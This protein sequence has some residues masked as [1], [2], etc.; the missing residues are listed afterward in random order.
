MSVRNVNP[1]IPTTRM[2]AE[3]MTGNWSIH[4]FGPYWYELSTVET[5]GRG[6]SGKWVSLSLMITAPAKLGN[7][8]VRTGGRRAR[9]SLEGTT[10][11]AGVRGQTYR[12]SDLNLIQQ[13]DRLQS[14]NNVNS[15]P[16]GGIIDR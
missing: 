5:G 4:G 7:T 6:M 12:P 13:N 2:M 8:R 11:I 9:G 3:S 10:Y 15:R 14:G 1:M 16:G